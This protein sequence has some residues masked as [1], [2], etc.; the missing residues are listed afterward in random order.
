MLG[1]CMQ[2]GSLVN[3]S[4]FFTWDGF[5]FH[6]WYDPGFSAFPSCNTTA[7]CPPQSICIPL[8]SMWQS[9]PDPLPQQFH[10]QFI[11][12][13]GSKSAFGCVNQKHPPGF[14]GNLWADRCLFQAA[15]KQKLH[16]TWLRIHSLLDVLAFLTNKLAM[17]DFTSKILPGLTCSYGFSSPTSG[18][19]SH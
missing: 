17:T 11:K 8:S 3:Q 14:R 5:D 18:Q 4:A 13:Q 1:C 7:I 6:V 16:A 9:A 15:L 12:K 19:P 2:P 10:T